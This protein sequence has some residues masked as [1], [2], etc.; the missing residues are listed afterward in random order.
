MAIK[1]AFIY[2]LFKKIVKAIYFKEIKVNF[3]L[4]FQT[5]ICDFEGR[6]DRR[7]I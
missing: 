3:E 5:T 6:S 2:Q 1:I 7:M 4:E